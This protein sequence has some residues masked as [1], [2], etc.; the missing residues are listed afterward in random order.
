MASKGKRS[1][2]KKEFTHSPRGLIHVDG[3]IS[4]ENETTFTVKYCNG[5]IK[6]KKCDMFNCHVR[7]DRSITLDLAE[8]QYPRARARTRLGHVEDTQRHVEENPEPKSE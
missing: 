7:P 4:H 5:R 3:T 1:P 6:I 8:T 2:V